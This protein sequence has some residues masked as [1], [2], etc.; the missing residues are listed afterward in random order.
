M[1]AACRDDSADEVAD[2]VEGPPD[3]SPTAL[4]ALPDDIEEASITV[5]DGG[6]EEDELEL[7][8]ERPTILRVTN[9]DDVAYVLRINPLVNGETIAPGATTKVEFTT[10]VE[11]TY[12][13]ELLP[14]SGGDAVDTVTVEVINAAGVPD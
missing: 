10:P 14:V 11:G 3:A 12:T 5:S 4:G 13:G 8:K 6:I 7:V 9:D 1:L 2:E